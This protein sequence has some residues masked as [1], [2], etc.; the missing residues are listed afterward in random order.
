MIKPLEPMLVGKLAPGETV[1]E[2]ATVLANSLLTDL[3]ERGGLL[4]GETSAESND[5]EIQFAHKS[6][7]EYLAAHACVLEPAYA[8]DLLDHW[9]EPYWQN[10]V[11]LYAA[12]SPAE[13]KVIKRLLNEATPA[14]TVLAGW[15]LY[16]QP[17][18]SPPLGEGQQ[19]RAR[20]HMLLAASDVASEHVEAALTILEAIDPLDLTATALAVLE[21]GPSA[22]VRARCATLLATMAQQSTVRAA[23]A[24]AASTDA[25]WRVRLAAADAIADGDPRFYGDGIIP[26]L[27][28][29][30]A[31]E[32][33]MGSLDD[34]QNADSNEKPQHI[35]DIPY[36]YWIGRTPV[37][38]AQFRAFA[39]GDGYTNRSYWTADGWEFINDTPLARKA[40]QEDVKRYSFETFAEYLKPSRWRDPGG[41]NLPV[42]NITWYEAAA[43][44]RWLSARTG[45]EWC[46]PSEAEW[47]KAARGT[48]GQIYPWGNSWEEGCCNSQELGLGRTTPV[49]CFPT[50][51]S[52]Y[53]ALDMAGNVWEW[54]STA[55]GTDYPLTEA[56][57]W[58]EALLEQDVLRRVRG[59][60][61][62]NER[63]FVR[64]PYRSNGSARTRYISN[65]VRVARRTPVRPP[66]S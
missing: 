46:L 24:S 33:L 64:A 26:D 7:Q 59:G 52:P 61:Y 58:K 18:T 16:E 44:C 57:D 62:Y 60:S 65:G 17:R 40:W 3:G 42:V 55:A 12:S 15:C 2:R 66:D 25:D 49:G 30:P 4:Q 28:H 35:L 63:R 8:V 27:V 56:N 5:A 14:A 32:F 10:I 36:D 53:G 22:V 54:C 39:H 34:D 47:E 20:L 31:G 37:T 45:G 43:Y 11:R 23:L 9:H 48:E 50:G 51:A 41:D 13:P 38:V 29:I 6:L 21:Q 1:K 19:V